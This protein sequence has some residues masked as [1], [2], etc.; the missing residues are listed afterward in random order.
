M[1]TKTLLNWALKLTA[2]VIMLQTL[3]FKF[4]SAPESIYIFSTMGME[5]WGRIGTG[6][7]ELMAS[8]LILYPRTTFFGAAM[9]LGTMAR[10]ILSH[11]LILG[12]DVQG[13]GGKLFALALITAVCCGILLIGHKNQGLGL[14]QKWYGKN[15]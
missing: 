4:T 5:P 12:I 14:I 11:L 7:V 10:A 9:G 13:D 1:N 3:F 6:V 15:H 2:A 8:L